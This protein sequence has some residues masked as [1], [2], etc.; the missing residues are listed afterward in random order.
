MVRT[1]PNK[2]NTVILRD[3]DETGQMFLF[4]FVASFRV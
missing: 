1:E 4:F 2:T 3:Y